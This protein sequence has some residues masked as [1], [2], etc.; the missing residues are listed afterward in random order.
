MK[1]I[2]KIIARGGSLIWRQVLAND[3]KWITNSSL[4]SWFFSWADFLWLNQF[5]H[6]FRLNL[7]VQAVD[8]ATCELEFGVEWFGSWNTSHALRHTPFVKGLGLPCS[9]DQF[10]ETLDLWKSVGNETISRNLRWSSL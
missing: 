2:C 8:Q 1:L 7:L 10:E 3:F 6:W 4:L 5:R 9:W